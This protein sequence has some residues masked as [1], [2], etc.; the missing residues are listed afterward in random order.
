MKRGEYA[1]QQVSKRLRNSGTGREKNFLCL[2]SG[3]LH[4]NLGCRFY[5]STQTIRDSHRDGRKAVNASFSQSFP[6]L[7]R[8]GESSILQLAYVEVDSLVRHPVSPCLVFVGYN[9]AICCHRRGLRR[10]ITKPWRAGPLNNLRHAV[11]RE[12]GAATHVQRVSRS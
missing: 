12:S 7:I 1:M 8:S 10:P 11:P 2:L 6:R 5:V 9:A 4:E 3:R